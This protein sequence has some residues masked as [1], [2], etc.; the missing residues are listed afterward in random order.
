MTPGP[1]ENYPWH[2]RR[3]VFQPLVMPVPRA[4][5]VNYRARRAGISKISETR[6]HHFDS[7]RFS[8]AALTS[9]IVEYYGPPYR[10]RVK[11]E[12]GKKP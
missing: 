3:Q 4:A 1:K 7:C 9:A 5:L 6:L 12:E 10:L 11:G 8:D 2:A